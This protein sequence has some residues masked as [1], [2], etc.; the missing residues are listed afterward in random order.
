MDP[1]PQGPL[2]GS[3]QGLS[4]DGVNSPLQG[5][6]PEEAGKRGSIKPRAIKTPLQKEALEA[7]YQVNHFPDE[8]V[9]R[10]LGERTGLTE[11]QV[12]VWFSHKRRKDKRND[13]VHDKVLGAG[14]NA[15][16]VPPQLDPNQALKDAL[17]STP[18]S[19]T[20]VGRGWPAIQ[21]SSSAPQGSGPSANGSAAASG[22]TAP[23]A[24]ANS[25]SGGGS[26]APSG[27][28]STL[29]SLPAYPGP[30]NT[31]LGGGSPAMGG[32]HSGLRPLPSYAST[33]QEGALQQ[34]Q[35]QRHF[36][37][38]H[39]LQQQQAQIQIQR[40]QQHA[41]DLQ[42]QQQ[43]HAQGSQQ[44]RHAEELF[45][46]QRQHDAAPGIPPGSPAWS[47]PQLQ[48]HLQMLHRMQQGPRLPDYQSANAASAPFVSPAA[49]AQRTN[50][51]QHAAI[52]AAQ[53]HAARPHA[54]PPPQLPSLASANPG[55]PLPGSVALHDALQQ[56]AAFSQ[57]P[58]QAST[59]HSPVGSSPSTLPQH[60]QHSQHAQL[61]SSHHPQPPGYP[62]GFPQASSPL[63][64]QVQHP[65]PRTGS[66]LRQ[67]HDLQGRPSNGIE[68]H[69]GPSTASHLQVQ[70]MQSKP[71][72]VDQ[73]SLHVQASAMHDASS[74]YLQQALQGRSSSADPALTHEQASAMH[75]TMMRLQQQPE[76]AGL[77]G[78]SSNRDSANT[79]EQ[80]SH[81]HNDSRPQLQMQQQLASHPSHGKERLQALL[82]LTPQQHRQLGSEPARGSD[83]GSAV[84]P[85]SMAHASPSLPEHFQQ[86]RAST[87]NSPLPAAPLH[88]LTPAPM[89]PYH[90]QHP[91]SASQMGVHSRAGISPV[92]ALKHGLFGQE[93]PSH[94]QRSRLG[95]SPSA[96]A[97][98]EASPEPM[99]ED[100][101]GSSGSDSEMDDDVEEDNGE[102][103]CGKS[104]SMGVPHAGDRQP[105]SHL[106]SQQS[107]YTP[108][109]DQ[110][111][112]YSPMPHYSPQAT[113]TGQQQ[114]AATAGITT[115]Q[116][117]RLAASSRSLS[118]DGHNASGQQQRAASHN[119][120]A[121]GD[122]GSNTVA[123]P[124]EQERYRRQQQ[125]FTQQ[126]QQ[127]KAQASALQQGSSSPVHAATEPL[128]PLSTYS[129]A[130]R[131]PEQDMKPLP[132]RDA[133]SRPQQGTPMG[134]TAPQ[135]PLPPLPKANVPP[136]P[137]HGASENVS[138][139][140]QEGR[141]PH[142]APV[143]SIVPGL[144]GPTS[145]IRQSMGQP[146]RTPQQ[147]GSEDEET[148]DEPEA[149]QMRQQTEA[150]ALYQA[151]IQALPEP[152]RA[153]GP[154]LAFE[155]DDPPGP[156]KCRKT[157]VTSRP[158]SAKPAPK[159][160]R[161]LSLPEST[162][163]ASDMA[164]DAPQDFAGE[165]PDAVGTSE[166]AN[167]EA[168]SE[169]EEDWGRE[170]E[171][172]GGGEGEIQASKRA[173][174]GGTSRS[175]KA[176]AE[177]AR[178]AA[179]DPERR[180]EEEIKK[181]LRESE[182]ATQLQK[183]L[184][185]TMRKEQ[186]RM[187]KER[188]RLEDKKAKDQ[189][190]EIE[191]REK[192][193]RK[194]MEKAEKEML[195]EEARRQKEE[196]KL[197]VI[198]DREAKKEEMRLDKEKRAEE[199][200]KAADIRKQEKEMLRALAQQEK[201]ATRLRQRDAQAGPP[202]DLDLELEALMEAKRAEG[203]GS[204]TG[205]MQT[206]QEV[207]RPPFPP[208][209][210]DLALAF[211]AELGNGLGP[212]LLMSWSFLHGFRDL[213]GLRSFSLDDLL[214][215]AI[216]G[217][218]SRLL[219][220]L[221]VGLLR[222]LQADMEEAHASGILQARGT[223]NFLDRSVVAAAT[224]LE[225]ATAWGIDV[226][227][228]RAHL[229]ANTWPE[230][231]RQWG[232]V[233][234]LGPKRARPRRE[235]KPKIGADGE[236]VV[237][238]D[239]GEL[240]LRMPARFDPGSVK[241]AAWQ[242]LTEVGPDGMT[243]NEIAR[244]IQTRNLRDLRSS[245]TPEASVAGALS[246]DRIFNRVSPATYAL[247]AVVNFHSGKTASGKLKSEAEGATPPEADKANGAASQHGDH[248]DDSGSESSDDELED[249]DKGREGGAAWITQLA[250][251][252]YD[253]FPLEQRLDVLQTLVHAAM[254]GPSVRLCLE[255]R[256]EE[257]QRIRKQM[258]DEAKVEK[259]KRQIEA[260]AKAKA[261]AE[262]AQ[263]NLERYR[264][265]GEPFPGM[266]A[267]G[268][269]E[270]TPSEAPAQIAGTGENGVG[271]D[272]A[273]AAAAAIAAVQARQEEEDQ[274]AT[275]ACKEQALQRAET[276]R[277]AEEAN[278]V[279]GEPLGCDRRFNRY[280]HM[281]AAG[282]GQ[283]VGRLYFENAAEDGTLHVL[284]SQA[285]LEELMVSL[286]RRGA[287]EGCLYNA[288]LRHKTSLLAA[289][290]AE[291]L[292]MPQR[293]E[294]MPPEARAR[295]AADQ[296]AWL[297]STAPASMQPKRDAL[298]AAAS[299]AAR[300][301]HPGDSARVTKFKADLLRASFTLPADAFSSQEK[302]EDWDAWR[303]A[304]READSPLRL[305]H[306]LGQL[307]AGVAAAWLSPLFQRDPC[308]VKGVWM[309]TGRETA[310]ARPLPNG[311]KPQL[312][313]RDRA[314]CA[315]LATS[316]GDPAAPL[317]WL[318]ATLPALELHF[319]CLR[320]AL[321][322]GPGQAPARDSL[323]GYK[324]IQ[325]PGPFAERDAD[326]RSYPA[327]GGPTVS[328][329][330]IVPG[331]RAK[332]SLFPAFPQALLHS[333]AS[334]FELPVRELKGEAPEP[335]A[336]ATS[337]GQQQPQAGGPTPMQQAPRRGGP[338][339][340]GAVSGR[341]MIGPPAQGHIRAII[342][343]RGV[344]QRGRGIAPKPKS[345]G[346]SALRGEFDKMS[347]D[348]DESE[349]D[350][351][352]NDDDDEF[353]RSSARGGYQARGSSY[354]HAGGYSAPGSE[355]GP[356]YGG[357]VTPAGSELQ[358]ESD[359][360]QQQGGEDDNDDVPL[361]ESDDN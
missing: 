57:S 152:F 345:R 214:A 120:A 16:R 289:F 37:H 184:E 50:L 143:S 357:A 137:K 245:K 39:S 107:E 256:L 15:V 178:L 77:Q 180:R 161:P 358:S 238:D 1:L 156:K 33:E 78:S 115:G 27:V 313:E 88:Q 42:Q 103:A 174:G 272:P 110:Q 154:R 318:P 293:A 52:Q 216:E 320:A 164:G 171:G 197:R 278:A 312:S 326:V 29:N 179:M 170:G 342:G 291:P 176:A 7:A 75:D 6:E 229:N 3:A 194:Q 62:M 79:H 211:P 22:S 160:K 165:L 100:V 92:E 239:S 281:L 186:E 18:S 277:R 182:K 265:T 321:S 30:S 304:V 65:R 67:Q 131:R 334:A 173:K 141:Q 219:G 134:D 317:A 324:C 132:R 97:P 94:Q 333:A 17:K 153:D 303:V 331:G 28:P 260:A 263:R 308:L 138:G 319:A 150:E 233:T 347:Q 40:H 337:L 301:L 51:L 218:S 228:W 82:A 349:P 243:I 60:I 157:P 199:R 355:M 118:P 299:P 202:D 259:R 223:T 267:E 227:A 322:H 74:D 8:S 38:Q 48:M 328:G 273:A 262:E 220:E 222:L 45:L 232:I 81:S 23:P 123:G 177:M 121:T 101:Q 290:P 158:T 271:Q 330:P 46:Q 54:R 224:C 84:E 207:V 102:G 201:Q 253:A 286:E 140:P 14:P 106:Y 325:K 91:T 35:Q 338:A 49:L 314:A 276:I 348:E 116:T 213:L 236:D 360:D 251:Q 200:K 168:R 237:A 9:R 212:V 230:V 247:Q 61:G 144:L 114:S 275:A 195:R 234:G 307:E 248:S 2:Q 90:P 298:G 359:V 183:R 64:N 163:P 151:A 241:G 280:W 300:P 59:F 339:R 44:Q 323:Q 332:P 55:V 185:N 133:P 315:A 329:L 352:D 295:W 188:R 351:E 11:Q 43:R 205:G 294:Q 71:S 305:R 210:I 336:P 10:T 198:Q 167:G 261:A 12:G 76:R 13:V 113:E 68:Q 196:E 296:Q 136:R 129:S 130:P 146:V 302:P 226:D 274:T 181:A 344:A 231:L 21:S 122:P 155:F 66:Q 53:Q 112:Y 83:S 117:S 204:D 306:L 24:T 172:D 139:K 283:P 264:I 87:P 235:L 310:S 250:E 225:E 80:A 297:W 63:H 266:P 159:R 36:Q 4:G 73:A 258:W 284:T 354:D 255:L 285:G 104:S 203:Y 135:Q 119:R 105:R 125:L 269:G 193:R 309:P 149:L 270:A 187:E 58:S 346:K 99:D 85:E 124:S 25:L 361:S 327:A 32:V 20:V 192:D 343:G 208:T 191:R 246:R 257:S 190:K 288:L 72:T 126:L 240:K 127:G 142:A 249:R 34:Q 335:Q 128:N 109:E 31:M 282:K 111:A 98:P 209:S 70:G 26:P 96:S 287:R 341:G 93:G 147:P 268:S 95:P 353:G 47:N 254:E 86:G 215:A 148:E 41:V 316:L 169:V 166:G 56:A 189:E 145:F 350:D 221:H 206:F 292:R 242:V 69:V 89:Q 244:Q 175:K 340:G 252:D 356:S 217:A 162:L 311:D 5:S 279:R 108:L 19:K